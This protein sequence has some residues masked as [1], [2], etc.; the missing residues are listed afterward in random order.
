MVMWDYDEE[1]HYKTI[2]KEGFD[3]G[4]E[5]GTDNINELN[6]WLFAQG[7]AKDV[8][9]ASKDK[10]YQKKLFKEY[11]KAMAVKI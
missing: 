8:E 2:A 4:F 5:Q 3:E 11:E 6:S 10:T 1:L 7:R 9:K